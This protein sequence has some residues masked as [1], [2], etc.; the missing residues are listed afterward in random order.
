MKNPTRILATRT[1]K[2][3]TACESAAPPHAPRF[4]AT[5][6]PPT[7]TISTRVPPDATAAPEEGARW[8]PARGSTPPRTD[9]TQ[10][11]RARDWKGGR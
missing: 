4:A 7:R 11:A 3:T 5:P 10:P 1:Y 6:Q 9:R 8:L 2:S